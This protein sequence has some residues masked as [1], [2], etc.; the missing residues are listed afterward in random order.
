MIRFLLVL[1]FVSIYCVNSKKGSKKPNNELGKQFN[2]DGVCLSK[3]EVKI[4]CIENFTLGQ[5]LIDAGNICK[6]PTETLSRKPMKGGK[7]PTKGG[8]KPTKGTSKGKG[9]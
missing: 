8:E 1:T 4:V 7:K 3:E 6:A 5:T 9:N 2:M